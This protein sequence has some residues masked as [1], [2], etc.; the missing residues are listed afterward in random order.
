M[1]VAEVTEGRRGV[2]KH[3]EREAGAR[4][5]AEGAPRR[6]R[7]EAGKRDVAR[8]EPGRHLRRRKL[9]QPRSRAVELLGARREL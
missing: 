8:A 2:K 6:A 4:D 3:L 7:R 9:R 1:S 5:R